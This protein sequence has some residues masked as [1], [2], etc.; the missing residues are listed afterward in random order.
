M[1]T[2]D[3][4]LPKPFVDAAT[5]THTYTPKRYSVTELLGGTCEAVL[6]R[7][8]MDEVTMDVAD[9]VWAIFGSAVHKVL[10]C[11]DAEDGQRQEMRMEHV[12]GNGYTVSGIADLYDTNEQK[13]TDYKTCSVWKFVKSEFD[14]WRMQTLLYCL[15]LKLNGMEATHGEIVAIMRDHQ[16]RDAAAKADY[17]KHPVDRVDWDFTDEDFDMAAAHVKEWLDKVAEQELLDDDDLEPCTDAQV[18]HKD[19]KWAVMKRGRKTAVKLF[20]NEANAT[21]L[22]NATVGG[23]VEC[24]KGEDTKCKSYCPVAQWC[25]RGRAAIENAG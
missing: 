13:V 14:D 2:N 16:M 21:E 5:G 3:L 19:D 24:R 4:N 17:P 12:F 18:W 7:R 15:L 20:D 23:Y 22:A 1:I 11:A 10:E 8:H 6:K 9:Q 25:K